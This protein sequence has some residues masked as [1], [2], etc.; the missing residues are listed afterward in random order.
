MN[1]TQGDILPFR[2]I[3]GGQSSGSSPP[4]EQGRLIA[5]LELAALYLRLPDDERGVLERC[6]TDARGWAE[7]RGAQCIRYPFSNIDA[8]KIEPADGADIDDALVWVQHLRRTCDYSTS[9]RD[10]IRAAMFG[11]E[12][13]IRSRTEADAETRRAN[14]R[15]I[16]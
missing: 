7:A 4:S 11:I 16:R 8:L 13:G 9:Q 12:E 5:A 14:I 15:V 1:R 3:E 6:A 10:F 2:V